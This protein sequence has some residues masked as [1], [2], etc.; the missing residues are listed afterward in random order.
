MADVMT[1]PGAMALVRMPDGPSSSAATWVSMAT[2]ALA[3][4]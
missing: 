1:R 3:E 2:A 4:Q